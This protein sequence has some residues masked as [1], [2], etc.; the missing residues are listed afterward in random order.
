M[1][2]PPPS[3]TPAQTPAQSALSIP[4]SLFLFALVYGGM[5][6][7]AGVL[8]YKQFAL[9]P[10]AVESGILAFLLLVVLS[11]TTS[12]VHGERT[13][14][15]LVLWGFAPL[16]LS[17]LLVL[18]VLALPAS[19]DMPPEN[20]AAFTQVHSQTP[21]IMVAGP[22]AY[23]V[24]L[25]LNVYLFNRMRRG[26]GNGSGGGAAGMMVRGALASAISQALDTLIFI[27][28]AFYGQFPIADLIV[29]Q[30]LAKV[31]LSL[32]LVPFL[33]Q[34]AVALARR[35]DGQAA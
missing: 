25:F 7:V 34:G 18:L 23:G 33:I 19:R 26:A 4:R 5:T 35:L 28:I 13:A 11:S 15:Q 20:L 8:A 14:N 22:I 3:R 10:L 16:G 1:D 6:V 29:G 27:T 9:G 21:R 17:I 2:N 12:Q 30:M 31:V 32:V 24:S